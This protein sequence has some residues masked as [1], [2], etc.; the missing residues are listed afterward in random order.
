MPNRNVFARITKRRQEVLRT[1]QTRAAELEPL[2]GY[3]A[4]KDAEAEVQK[5][6]AEALAEA[7]ALRE[8]AKRLVDQTHD[9]AAEQRVRA[10]QRVKEIAAQ[11]DAL[12]TQA[13]RDAGRLVA[14]AEKRAKQT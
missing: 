5:V 4:L 3:A 2:R 12:L 1:K 9:A 6:L 10:Q 8:E 14:E 7:T 11:A 13:T